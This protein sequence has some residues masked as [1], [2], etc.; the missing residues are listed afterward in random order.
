ML[1]YAVSQ[2]TS[3]LKT[4]LQVDDLL[5]DIWVRGEVRN[6][7]RPGSGHSY[8]SLGDASG[9]ISCVMF[10]QSRGTD[11]LMTGGEILAHGRISL[12][13][14]RG[15]LQFIV[16]LV[17]PEG[18]GELQLQLERLKLKLQEDGLFEVNRKR[19]LPPFPKRLG[20]VTSA[21]GAVWRDIQNVISRRY[22]LVQLVLA[23]TAVQGE[24]AEI[25]IVEA[26]RLLNDSGNVDVIIVA[27]G[28][29]SLEDLWAFN[30]EAVARAIYGSGVPIISAIG[31]ETDHTICDLAADVRAPTP[32]AGAELAVP[33]ILELSRHLNGLHRSLYR[34]VKEI[35]GS[36]LEH[37][38]VTEMRLDRALPHIDDFRRRIDDLLISG[39][40]N[41]R[42]TMELKQNA[43][44]IMRA[45]LES[46]SP[47]GTLQ[48]GY[49]VIQ[50]N[51]NKAVVTSS[52]E[53]S[54]GD[55]IDVILKTGELEAEVISSL[56]GI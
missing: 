47:E 36:G 52:S 38:G 31:H 45:S 3:Y 15:Q 50:R 44:S 46:L 22:P 27:R 13:E 55:R 8:F 30:S 51:D 5:A 21:D 10:K 7:A 4:L 23:P 42:H 17:Q 54:A 1:V 11:C 25:G 56:S 32:S 37:V 28:G 43:T 34:G 18:S 2:V 6:L 53:V 35:L 41:A 39:Y 24:D 33:D 48:R 20:V 26:V 19:A 29:G 16:D 40:K 14:I 49:S 12:Y 9:S